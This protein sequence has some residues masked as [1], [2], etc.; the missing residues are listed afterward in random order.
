MMDSKFPPGQTHASGR[1]GQDSPFRSESA[2]EIQPT[3]GV[4]QS[5]EQVGEMESDLW[6][7]SQP[8]P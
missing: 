1:W 8:N 3:P 5:L 4:S 7:G 6:K 2:A